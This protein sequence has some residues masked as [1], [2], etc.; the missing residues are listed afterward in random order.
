MKNLRKDIYAV[1]GSPISHSKSPDIYNFLFEKYSINAVYISI[2][3]TLNSVNIFFENFLESMNIK[4]I[5]VTM[6]LKEA[7][8]NKA[9]VLDDT[10]KKLMSVNTFC[11]KENKGY[12]TDGKGLLL[13]LKYQG[14]DVKNKKVVVLGAGGAAKSVCFELKKAKANIAIVNRTVNKANELANIIGQASV[15]SMSDIA[16]AVKDCD[17]LINCTNLG[18]NGYEFDD[19]SFVDVMKKDVF[20]YDIVYNPKETKLLKRGKEN[21]FRSCNGMDMLIC[22]ALYAFEIFCGIKPTKQDRDKLLGML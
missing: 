12:T 14:I 4:G 11:T 15:F 2:E 9:K 18:M 21:G 6:P 22:Q 1:V 7:I 5:N 16:G 19:L 10:S 20:V 3:L 17:V 8:A 13:S